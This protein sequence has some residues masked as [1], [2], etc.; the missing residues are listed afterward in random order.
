MNIKE[1]LRKILNRRTSPQ[2]LA[3]EVIIS[4]EER[5]QKGEKDPIDN[6]V[7]EA[8]RIINENP[9]I[10]REIAKEIL[11]EFI[12]NEKIP[13]SLFAKT[14][15]EIALTPEIP[16]TVI[17]QAV[18]QTEKQVSGE[19]IE[20]IIE[21][22]KVDPEARLKLIQNVDDLE[23]VKRR[24]KNELK[25]LYSNC[26]GKQDREIVDRLQ[27]IESVLEAKDITSEIQDLVYQVISKK[28]A[29]NY[30][31]DK[32]R[33]TKIYEFSTIISFEEMIESGLPEMVEKEY[34][35][36]E[37]KGGEKRDRFSKTK[38]T[39][40]ILDKMANDIA[41]KYGEIGIIV[42]P[43]SENMKKL[44]LEEEKSFI[45]AI[46]NF[47]RENLSK[48]DIKDVHEQIRGNIASN[49]VKEEILIG[50]IKKIP[51]SEKS[52]YIGLLTEIIEDS[53]TLETLKIMQNSGLL[54][55]LKNMP[56]EERKTGVEAIEEVLEKREKIHV[57]TQTL[58]MPGNPQVDIFVG[59]DSVQR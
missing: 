53:E 3:E 51:Y 29:E 18:Q 59:N 14:A 56:E 31:D 42:I 34:Q 50:K 37:E 40:L 2:K 58:K 38:L 54:E 27:K 8:K 44:S 15:K 10:A 13:E 32:L 28:M 45:K 12:E 9:D 11:K 4:F 5:K 20:K 30:Y 1:I 43:Q 16:D 36:L 22:G 33:A 57:A 35:M 6:T 47:S 19:V 41:K 46:Q 39:Q 26:K 17:S 7:E 25:V 24:V 52:E 21:E 23:I 49:Q 55:K 48:E